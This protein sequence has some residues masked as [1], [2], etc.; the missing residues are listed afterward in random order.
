MTF[1]VRGRRCEET[2]TAARLRAETA[3]ARARDLI[4]EGWQVFIECQDDTRS[5]PDDF[6]TLLC[7]ARDDTWLPL[8][9]TESE[10]D[11]AVNA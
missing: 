1:I 8:R 6:D 9:Q 4:A 7:D 3:I 11:V 5:Y 2:A 10:L